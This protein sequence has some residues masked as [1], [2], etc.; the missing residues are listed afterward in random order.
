MY[1]QHDDDFRAH[2]AQTLSQDTTN[3]FDAVVPKDVK[4]IVAIAGGLD[5]VQK[6]TLHKTLRVQ[7][8][9]EKRHCRNKRSKKV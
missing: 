9:V 5:R 3:K 6:K 2:T 1:R 7:T 4:R 8:D